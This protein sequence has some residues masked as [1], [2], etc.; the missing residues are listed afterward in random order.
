ADESGARRAVSLDY[1][2]A[3]LAFATTLLDGLAR[4]GVGHVVIC[5]GSRSTPLALAA[6][7]HPGLRH[8]VLVD[9]RSAAY[10]ALGAARQLGAPVAL[11]CTSGTA[12]ANFAPAVIE[13]D[14][15]RV[16][17]VVLTADRPAELRDWGAAQT[18]DQVH[19]YGRHARWFVDLPAPVGDPVEPRLARATAARAAT[20]AMADGG[21]PVHLNV[22][23]REPLIPPDVDPVPLVRELL[24]VSPEPTLPRHS[25]APPPSAT[26][27]ALVDAVRAHPHGIVVCGPD[28]HNI[29]EDVAQF[30]TASGYPVLADPVS[31]VRFA[32]PDRALLSDTYDL[33]LR[34]SEIANHLTPDL[35]IR[36]GGTPTSKPLAQFLARHAAPAIVI[37]PGD[38]RDANHLAGWH[39]AAD[40]AATL[41][42]TADSLFAGGPV[43]NASWIAAWQRAEDTTRNAIAD[44]LVT[45]TV[46]SEI[47][48]AAELPALLPRGSTLVAGNSMPVRDLDTY[49]RG[50]DL[51]IR[52]AGTRGASG[53]DGVT[54]TALGA[55][56]VA[57]GPVA[58]LVGDLSFLHDLGGLQAA[59]H[60][61][62]SLVIVVVNNDGGGIFSFLPQHTQLPAELYEALF[63]TPTGLDVQQVA[64]LFGLRYVQPQSIGQFRDAVSAGLAQPGVS[65]VEVRT[66]REDNL[67]LHRRIAAAVLERVREGRTA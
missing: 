60:A 46:L 33:F 66:N 55:A 39:I 31:G 3:N 58:L 2:A 11:I 52:A 63:G 20:V 40:V 14:L 65:V 28:H 12:A 9:E 10:F 54:S 32:W 21:G 51:G 35:V 56:A 13:A 53:I 29:A 16:P 17:L 6:A 27:Y 26:V 49:A 25:S 61:A 8:W 50:G 47:R 67:T 7:L 37:D 30:A 34:D 36:I 19:L 41:D 22:Q 18:I 45:S 1:G 42:E 62:K 48:V 57:T 5:P 24:T 59:R 44:Q 38:L 64:G 23:F 15:S 43:D 4:N